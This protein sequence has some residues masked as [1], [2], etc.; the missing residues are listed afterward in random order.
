MKF[1]VEEK[2]FNAE[3]VASGIKKLKEMRGKGTQQRMDSFF[4][5]TGVVSSSKRKA[6]PAKAKPSKK[7]KIVKGKK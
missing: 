3:R 5:S 2:G 7:G 1:L 4:K 6:E